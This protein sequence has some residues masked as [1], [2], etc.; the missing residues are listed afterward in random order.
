MKIGSISM[1]RLLVSA[2]LVWTS[3]T[4]ISFVAIRTTIGLGLRYICVLLRTLYPMLARHGHQ[5]SIDVSNSEY[6][7][8]LFRFTPIAASTLFSCM[9]FSQ[10]SPPFTVQ[11]RVHRNGQLNKSENTN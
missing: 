2:L 10:C 7:F 8:A 3:R 4:Y 6:R 9:P 1:D 5:T 11:L